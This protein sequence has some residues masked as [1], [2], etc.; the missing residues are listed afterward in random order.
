MPA[1]SDVDPARVRRRIEPLDLLML[2]MT[3]AAGLW[4]IDPIYDI[5]DVFWHILLGDQIRAGTPFAE[6]GSTFSFSVENPD[7]RTGA[8][9]SEFLMSWL[10]D[11]G[12]WTLLVNVL[13]LGSIAG[14]TFVFWRNMVRRWPSRAVLL[15]Y[16]L[17]MIALA[18]TIQERPQSVSY[19][20]IALAGVWWYRSVI[21]DRPPHWLL[22]GLTAALWA[23][24]HGLWVLLPGVMALA[25]VGRLLNRGL[26]D[27]L[28]VPMAAAL[29][30]SLVGG[31]LT[32]LGPSGLLLA[33][34][35]QDSATNLINERA[36]TTLFGWPGY[37]LLVAGALA[38]YLL[39]RAAEATR[40]ELLYVLAIGAFGLM[41]ERNVTPAVLLLTPLLAML[42][43]RALGRRAEVSVSLRERSRLTVMATV[44]AAI[45]VLSVG[46]TIGIRDQG[47]PDSLPV[48]LAA[49]LADEPAPVRLLNDYN[50]SGVALFYGGA[51]LQGGADGRADYYGAD[52]LTRYQ[53]A[54]VFGHDLRPL[55]EDLDPTHALVPTDSATAA[56]LQDDG[57]TVVDSDED[58]ILLVAP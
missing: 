47:P 51:D 19:V 16:V 20:F 31:C 15:P 39:G 38:L 5:N 48:A 35:I 2:V 57:W 9:G 49:R 21:D 25:F 8:W 32:P 29:L 12:G 42:I 6:L 40:A 53:D 50:W 43:S 13:R 41:A 10:Y 30:T 58:H 54:V 46:L 11:L 55:V 17:A 18:L 45:G 7:W 28:R 24:L 33:V 44:T 34:R 23:N 3:F 26:G 56:I 36:P 27:P 22:V 4:V 37:V 52:F 14:V 1:K